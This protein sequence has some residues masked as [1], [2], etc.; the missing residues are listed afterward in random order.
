MTYSFGDISCVMSHPTY[1]SFTLMG[2]G[3]GSIN[4]SMSNDVSYHDVAG[5][6]TVMV[7]KVRA[8]NGTV[9]L[10]V[11]QTSS[12]N[13]WL[14]GLYNYLLTAPTAEWEQLTIDVNAMNIEQKT[15]CNRV[16]FQKFA[17]KPYQQQGQTVTW[18][19]LAADVNHLTA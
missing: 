7:S 5:D 15:L 8:K 6:G 3:I 18:N 9:G 12:L 2:E 17:D 4:I 13:K 10:A 14:T 11:Q 16:S 1:G 19:L